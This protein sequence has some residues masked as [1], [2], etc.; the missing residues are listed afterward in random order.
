MDRTG[1][2]ISA[3]VLLIG[4]SSVARAQSNDLPAELAHCLNFTGAV[5][6]LSCYDRLA[7]EAGSIA[8]RDRNAV[9]PPPQ[10]R[11]AA[12]PAPDRL[13][14]EELPG[15]SAPPR[16]DRMTAEITDFRKDQAG[17]FTVALSNGQVWQQVAGDTTEARYRP[18]NTHSVTIS[19]GSLGSYDLNFNDRNTTFKVRRLH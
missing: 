5:E 18:G 10:A 3:V 6:R 12:G 9:P 11:A 4:V 19:R 15:R 17:R 8:P 1:C 13:G 16:E 14:K 7:R 2:A